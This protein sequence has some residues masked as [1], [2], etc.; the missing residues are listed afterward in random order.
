MVGLGGAIGAAAGVVGGLL[1]AGGKSLGLTK[2]IITPLTPAPDLKPIDEK[3]IEVLFNPKSYSILKPVH[4]TEVTP[5][6]LLNAPEL[7]FGGGS[8]RTM[9]LNLFFDVT[10]PIQRKG[11]AVVIDDV[12]KETQKIAQLTRIYR[13]DK[14]KE[15]LPPVCKVSWGEA[16]KGYDFPFYGVITSLTQNFTLFR[17]DGIPVRAELTVEF[18][19]YGRPEPDRRETDPEL[20]THLVVQGDTLSSIATKF[21]HNP[22]LW[23][24]IAEENQLDDPRNLSGAIGR[25][26]RIPKLR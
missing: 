9:T 18:R 1:G 12:R 5:T 10:E 13:D 23:R 26:L 19:E 2:L 14:N 17:S 7:T 22:A 20:T 16:Q 3:E 6:R 4:W 8:S 11:R 24:I 25:R 21:Y 15:I